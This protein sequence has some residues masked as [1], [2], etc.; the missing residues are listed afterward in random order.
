[1]DDEKK[2]L[3]IKIAII[4]ALVAGGV[5]LYQNYYPLFWNGYG[6]YHMGRGMGGHW[7]MGLMMPL[8]WVLIF[9]IVLSLIGRTG[10][11]RRENCS[12]P[13]K[14]DTVLSSIV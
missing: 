8:F 6:G 4:G 14:T 13:V 2:S 5:F 12:G 7:G 3:F 11:D 10:R 1:V 9:V